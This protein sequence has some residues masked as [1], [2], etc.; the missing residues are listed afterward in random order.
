MSDNS[1]GDKSAKRNVFGHSQSP[2]EKPRHFRQTMLRLADYLKDY[3]GQIVITV[4]LTLGGVILTVIGPRVLGDMINRITDDYSANKVYES[5]KRSLPQQTKLPVGTTVKQLMERTPAPERDKLTTR[6]AKL[7]DNQRRKIMALDITKKPNYHFDTMASTGLWLV[8]I[9]IVGAILGYLEGWV[10]VGVTQRAVYR[11]RRE[12]S[13][14][15][16]TL[17]LSYFDRHSYGDVLS[18]ITNDV[19]MVSQ[20]LSGIITQAFQSVATVVGILVMM[21]SINLMLTGAVML[22]LPISAIVVGVVFRLS[23]KYFASQQEI[24]GKLNGYIEETYS[25]HNIVKIFGGEKRAISKFNRYNNDLYRSSWRAQFIAGVVYPMMEFVG[26][27]GFLITIT[28]GGYQVI[29]GRLQVGDIQA[30]S[31]YI[32]QFNQPITQIADLTGLIQSIIAASERVFSFIDQSDE[33]ITWQKGGQT[34]SQVTG[35]ISFDHVKFGYDSDRPVIHDLSVEIKPGQKVAIVGPTGAGKTTI[36]NLLMRFYDPDEGIIKLDG[37]DTKQIS[38]HNIRRNFGMV[39]QDT[40]LF[41]GTIKENLLYGKPD[42]SE[43][44]L[45]VAIE[46]AM[47][48]HVIKSLPDG[49]NTILGESADN[50]SAGEKQLLTIARAMLANAP[51]TI[52]DEATSNVD[53]RTERLIQQAM[54]KLVEGRTSFVIAHRLST[55]RN[56]DLILVIDHGDIVESGTHDSLLEQNGFYA[57]LYNA[58]FAH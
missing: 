5:V 15:I 10:I 30:F 45:R 23:Q 53:T 55:I 38:R 12:I 35:Q 33:A 44:E 52:L 6:L 26:N 27:L 34:I 21:V 8:A 1:K 28:L 16:N 57:K 22:T 13:H 36:V 25:G 48:D 39:L 42:A 47:V 41:E 54:D 29:K 2:A 4:I 50:I 17:P 14:K 7:P 31:Q 43:E 49:M 37:V 18:R 56:A 46:T 9:Y 19:D 3:T 51:I 11:L 24:L 32:R 20:N 58:Q 40:W